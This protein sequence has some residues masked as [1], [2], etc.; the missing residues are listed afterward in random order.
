MRAFGDRAVL[1]TVSGTVAARA[2][3]ADLGADLEEWASTA[4]CE[5]V[6]GLASVVVTCR[7]PELAEGITQRVA[8]AAAHPPVAS[9]PESAEPALSIPVV[10]DGPDL[11]EV[12]AMAGCSSIEL[13]E[14][15]TAAPLTVAM[16]GFSPGFAFLEGLPDP[17]R[18]LP[19]RAPPRPA[20]PPGSVALA[21]GYAAVYPSASPGGW[22]LVGRTGLSMFSTAPPYARVR[23]GQLVRFVVSAADET[24]MPE[25]AVEWEPS[26]E[27]RP[28][29]RVSAPGLRTVLQDRGRVGFTHLGVPAAGPADPHSFALANRLVGNGPEGA[30][31]EI[32]A[33]GPTLGV[34][35]EGYASVLGGAPDIRL[36]G[37]VMEPG[38][39]FP[40]H[41]G[42]ELVVGDVRRGFRTY[43]AVAGGFAGPHVLGSV[44]RDQL[45]GHGPGAIETGDTLWVNQMIPPLGSH[46]DDPGVQKEEGQLVALRVVPGPHAEWFEDDALSRLATMIY[47]VEPVSNRVGLRL[48]AGSTVPLR[49]TSAAGQEL[50]SQGMV[51][52][53]IQ[54]PPDERPVVLLPDHA[55]HGGYP[56]IAVVATVDLGLL[57]QCAPGDSIRFVAIELSEAREL[58]AEQRRTHGRAVVSHYP[59]MVE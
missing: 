8:E 56:V 38:R 3:A 11:N 7:D 14:L 22:N 12:A 30:A 21:N 45:S 47:R 58:S 27:A 41:L 20:V 50:M 52:G 51:H 37:Q 48:S 34:L 36:D 15:L 23:A 55:T 59:L 29:F 4:A 40:F 53:A 54:V 33:R 18:A 57:G 46:L 24:P 49:A 10:F 13:T 35:A 43:L 9:S 28:F 25:E 1:V 16:L 42:Q 39:V 32:T 2:L 26:R 44:A 5:V 31:L 17:L 19:R 6:G